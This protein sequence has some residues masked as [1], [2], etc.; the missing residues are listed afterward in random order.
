MSFRIFV[1]SL[2]M[3]VLTGCQASRP[4]DVF[5]IKPAW[6]HQVEGLTHYSLANNYNIWVQ[7]S[8]I[9][10]LADVKD[11][12]LVKDH[13]KR[14]AAMIELNAAGTARMSRFTSG[15]EQQP[16]AFFVDDLLVSAPMVQSG[17]GSKLMVMGIGDK[18]AVDQFIAN[19]L[20]E[21]AKSN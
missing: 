5:S 4:G 15:H 20:A 6:D 2:L 21:A 12:W 3:V 1:Y 9:V 8:S 19:C 14:P 10:T 17:L 18:A 16:L 13:L 7:P 11:A